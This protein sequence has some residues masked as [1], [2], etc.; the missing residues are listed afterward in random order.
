MVFGVIL[1]TMKSSGGLAG[2]TK[3]R[4]NKIQIEKKILFFCFLLYKIINY[5]LL[6]MI[7]S[8]LVII[9]RE[10]TCF[11]S[12]TSNSFTHWSITFCRPS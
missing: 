9:E 12:E 5:T 7:P 3:D 8:P 2:A 10:R 1:F 6:I 11:I 4:K